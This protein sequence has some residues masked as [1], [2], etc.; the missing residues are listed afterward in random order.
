MDPERDRN[1]PV[2]S[3][4]WTINGFNGVSAISGASGALLLNSI[5]AWLSVRLSRVT[6]RL[7][8]VRVWPTSFFVRSKL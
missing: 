4:A 5:S 2:V 6:L 3:L 8:L 1:C 7:S